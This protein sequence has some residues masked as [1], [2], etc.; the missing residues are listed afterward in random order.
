MI[1]NVRRTI[2]LFWHADTLKVLPLCLLC[3]NLEGFF[4][5]TVSQGR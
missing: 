2:S 4:F 1:R 5:A 3:G